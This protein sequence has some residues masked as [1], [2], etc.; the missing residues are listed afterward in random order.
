MECG[1]RK[2]GIE[3]GQP[4]QARDDGGLH[5]GICGGGEEGYGSLPESKAHTSIAF[6]FVKQVTVFSTY[7]IFC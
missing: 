4:V 3:A 7:F 6:K 5:R 2:R 1:V